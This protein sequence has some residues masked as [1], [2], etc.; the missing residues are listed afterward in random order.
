TKKLSTNVFT[1]LSRAASA[2]QG[3]NRDFAALY[4]QINADIATLVAAPAELAATLGAFIRL[5]ALADTGDVAS[6]MSAYGDLAGSVYDSPAGNPG[7]AFQS[8]TA[9]ATRHVRIAND[10]H[11]SDCFA[12]NALAGAV[13]SCGGNPIDGTGKPSRRPLFSTKPEA[14]G[15]ADA[16]LSQWDAYVAWR[17]E[18]FAAL[19]DAPDLGAWQVDTGESYQSLQRAVAVTAGFLVKLSFSLAKERRVLLAEATTPFNLA[20]RFYGRADNDTL[21]KIIN[22]NN[23]VGEEF[24]SVPKGRLIKYYPAPTRASA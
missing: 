18:G 7:T 22:T 4:E 5:P 15:A 19:K 24:F 6:R 20:A 16:L 11:A 21:D 12:G 9:L 13:L 10:F 1:T 17:D 14:I 23:L 3:V 2:V 8:G